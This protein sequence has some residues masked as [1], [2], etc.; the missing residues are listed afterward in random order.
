MAVSERRVR[1]RGLAAIWKTSSSPQNAISA[2][3]VH[4]NRDGSVN[5]SVGAV[6][7]G[8]GTK[9]TVA[10]ILA[11]ALGLPVERVHVHLDV[12]TSTA[13][14]HW[15]TVA[16]MG[17]FMV[18]RAVLEAAQDAVSQLRRIAGIALRCP[19]DDLEVDGGRVYLSAA[20]ARRASSMVVHGLV[21]M[22]R[23]AQGAQTLEWLRSNIYRCTGCEEIEAAARAALAEARAAAGAE[24]RG[25]APH[26]GARP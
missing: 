3:V 26:A 16:S 11:D 1:G 20:T 23:E 21:A 18:G 9:T 17:T 6:E 25:A 2:A 14:E 7:C 10:Q 19:P 5:L 8:A 4:F 15:K 24:A 12:R 13:P 22:H